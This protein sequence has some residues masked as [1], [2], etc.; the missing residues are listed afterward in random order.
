M[1]T[2]SLW[3]DITRTRPKFPALS[4]D[5][6]ADVLIIGGGITGITC[7]LELT[8]RG[9][10]VVLL[11]AQSISGGTTGYSTGNLYTATQPYY[12]D[13]VSKFDID[14]ARIVAQSRK[15]A[16]DYIEKN[17]NENNIDCGFMRR[18]WYIY[19]QKERKITAT[20]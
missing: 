17:V 4:K 12:K 15:N 13:I 3:K 8:R 16:I 10:K 7:A 14:T 5:L 2:V 9:M 19:Q 20:R 6:T 1:D 11:E 18:P